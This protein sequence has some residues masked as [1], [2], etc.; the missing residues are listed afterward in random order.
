M[1]LQGHGVFSGQVACG[2]NRGATGKEKPSCMT[3]WLFYQDF[4]R[5]R[6]QVTGRRRLFFGGGG[7]RQ[8]GQ[9]THVRLQCGRNGHTAV[10]LLEIFQQCHQC[11][12]YGET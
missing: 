9:T 3:G 4:V 6:L 7:R 8:S 11:P 2:T 5:Y 12:A 1:T 10:G